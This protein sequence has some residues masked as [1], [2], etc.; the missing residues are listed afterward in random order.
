[1]WYV[2]ET[3]SALPISPGFAEEAD[4]EE[5]RLRMLAVLKK[6]FPGE[7]FCDRMGVAFFVDNNLNMI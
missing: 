3:G 2:I 7:T 1:M 4:A 6:A 5:E